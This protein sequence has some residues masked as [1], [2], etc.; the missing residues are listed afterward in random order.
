M[1]A[2]RTVD[3]D[4]V[5]LA[6]FDE[7][8]GPAVLFV[9]GYPLDHSMWNEQRAACEGFRII[10][11]DLRGF[12]D[13][14]ATSGAV[15]MDR[16]AADLHVCLDQLGA[17]EPIVY[18]GLSMGGYVAWPFLEQR[19][20]RVRGLVLA[21]TR[22]VADTPATAKTRRETAQKVV[23]DGVR[24]IEDAML[25]KQF[26]EMTKK[27]KP[28]VIEQ[29]RSMIRRAKPDGVAGALLGMADRSDVSDRLSSLSI[30]T[31][32]VAGADDS[33]VSATEM[34]GFARAFPNAEFIRVERAGHVTPM[35]N[36][37]AF[38]EALVK[39]LRRV[40]AG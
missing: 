40:T 7:G 34:E 22:V 8:Q 15:S 38:N 1:A 39:F 10:A 19:K 9:H 12:G 29:A 13:S 30:P 4:G 31:L 6:V 20:D 2:N 24:V 18:V 25:D 23:A 36:P 5:Q 16:F 17:T 35:E 14:A 21:N 37:S 32:V 3:V 27:G 11:P 26:S 33:I 28:Q